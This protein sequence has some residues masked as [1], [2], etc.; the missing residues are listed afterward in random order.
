MF[1]PTCPLIEISPA[2]VRVLPTSQGTMK[3]L[4]R[5]MSHA[6]WNQAFRNLSFVVIHDDHLLG[7]ICLAAPVPRLKVRDDFLFPGLSPPHTTRLRSYMDMSVCVGAQPC[8]WHWNLGKLCAMLAPT[9]GDYVMDRYGDELRGITTTSWHGTSGGTQ[10]TRVYKLLGKTKGY[11][12]A[13][14]PKETMVQ[15]RAWA[16]ENGYRR[17]NSLPIGHPHA[18]NGDYESKT[19]P[20]RRWHTI[21]QFNEYAESVGWDEERIAER[22]Y[23]RGERWMRGDGSSYKQRTLLFLKRVVPP[24]MLPE[25]VDYHGNQRG[26]YYHAA[27]PPEERSAVVHEWYERWGKPRYESTKNRTPPYASGLAIDSAQSVQRVE[28]FGVAD[29]QQLCLYG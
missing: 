29:F 1:D 3:V 16:A 2:R 19:L 4:Q 12:Q 10:Y 28:Q 22:Y 26:V 15:L 18:T 9:L 6:P 17:N 14:I 21:Q 8:A 7:L 13:H 24:E 25:K 5:Q 11:G 20:N 27:R 23:K